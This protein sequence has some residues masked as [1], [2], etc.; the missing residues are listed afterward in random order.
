M[1]RPLPAIAATLLLAGSGIL[2]GSPAA[3]ADSRSPVA[4]SH[5]KWATPANRAGN[6]DT[7]KKLSFRVYLQ[8]R[9]RAGAEAAARAVSDPKSASYGDYLTPDKVRQRFAPQASSVSAVRSWLQ[10]NGFKVGEVPANNLYVEASG[11][12]ANVEKAFGVN[13]AMYRVQ[14]STLRAPDHDLSVPGS[15][16]SVVSGV[17]GV[18]QAQNLFRP[19]HT[20]GDGAGAGNAR[21]NAAA[22]AAAPSTAPPSPGFR[23]ARPCS[24]YFGEK[25]Y[26]TNPEYG[27]GFPT[28]LPYAPCGYKP[29]QLRSAYGLD[30]VKGDGSGVTVAI[31]DAFASPTILQDAQKYAQRNDPTHPLQKNQFSQ[32]VFPENAADEEL[33]DASGWYGEETLDVEAVHAMA[34]GAKIL[35]VGGSDCEDASLDKALN[36]VIAHNKAQIVSNSYGDLGEDVPADL[37]DAFEQ[38]AI[39]GALQ[40]IGVYFSSGDY[41]DNTFML[42]GEAPQPDFSAS[43]PWVTAVGGTSLAIGANGKRLFETGWET[44]K[45]TLSKGA[46]TPAAPGGYTSGS[47]GG[48]SHLFAEPFYQKGVVPDALAGQGQTGNNRGRVVPDISMVGDPN[49]GFLVGQ[50]QTFPDGVYYD[51]YRIGGTSLSSPLLAGLMAVADQVAKQNHR[52]RHGFINPWLYQFTSR[53]QAVTDVQHVTAADVRVDYANGVDATDGLTTS[54]RTFDWPGLSIHTAKGYDNVTGLGVPNAPLFTSWLLP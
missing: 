29:A 3:F 9:D 2:A 11:T 12:V 40:G 47:G 26:T 45:S 33:C 22:S 54:V 43:S 44:G 48:T 8:M 42:P 20:T 21:G 15:I 36:Y 53:T 10:S 38:I 52:P 27:G 34:P 17:V 51:E 46:W 6:A 1:R 25:T 5:P 39:Q 28:T 50:T 16:S 31:V 18:D 30:Q 49:T 14:G 24:A 13:L 32:Y 4:G 35:Y 37:V 19:M 23:N 41:G 7:A